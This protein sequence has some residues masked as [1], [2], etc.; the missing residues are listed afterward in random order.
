M[1]DKAFWSWIEKRN[2]AR[3]QLALN[4][5]SLLKGAGVATVLSLGGGKLLVPGVAAQS[6]PTLDGV[7]LRVFT[8]TGP[9]ISGPD[10]GQKTL[11]HSAPRYD[12][13]VEVRRS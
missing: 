11:G 5:R 10:I 9:F 6:E 13:N 7:T 3:E 4:R 12:G 8:T 2:M 1:S